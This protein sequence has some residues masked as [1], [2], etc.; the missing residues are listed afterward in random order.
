ML[1]LLGLCRFSYPALADFQTSHADLAAR[2]AALFA[3]ERL[4]LRLMWFRHILLPAIR[5]QTDP[6][7]TL[8][9]LLGEDLPEPWRGR[10]LEAVG[11]VRQIVPVFRP[12]MNHRAV[13]REVL[14]EARDQDADWVAEFRLDDDDAVAVDFVERARR[15]FAAHVRGLAEEHGSALLD[16]QRGLV[17]EAGPEGLALHPLV[18]RAWAAGLCLIY[19]PSEPTALMDYPHH[20]V[21]WRMPCVSRPEV[22]MFLRGAHGTNDSL[23]NRR[24][25]ITLKMGQP[26]VRRILKSR[27]AVDLPAFRQALAAL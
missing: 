24:E 18:A 5:A 14:M 22:M 27:F 10:L 25:G 2:K 4:D 17:V 1:Q 21:W 13:C 7:F 9:L 16:Y 20:R 8:L 6:D 19:P 26:A 3:P 11:E 23:V 12:P 15:D